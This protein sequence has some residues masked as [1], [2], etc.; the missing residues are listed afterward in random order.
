MRGI[1]LLV[2]LFC[3]S[4]TRIYSQPVVWNSGSMRKISTPAK[5]YT[6]YPRMIELNDRSW[7]CIYEVDGDIRCAKSL[8]QGSTWE[9]VS[10]VAVRE[11]EVNMCVPSVIQLEDGSLLAMYNP[12]PT[13]D[14]TAHHFEIRSKKSYD[15]GLTWRD[16]RLVYQAGN[17]FKNGCWEPAAIQLPSGEIR[18]F[19]ANEGLYIRS[20]EQNISQ[21]TSFDNGLSWSKK[22]VIVSFR[23]GFR[24]GMPIPLLLGRRKIAIAIE[25]NGF[26]QFKPYVIYSEIINDRIYPVLAKDSNRI[27]AL[28]H[29]LADSIYAGAPYLCKL[30]NGTTLLSYQGTEGRK[31]QM[32]Y[33]DMKVMVGDTLAANFEHRSVPFQ[34]P[35]DKSALWNSLMVTSDDTIVAL[36]ATN[37]FNEGKTEIWMIKGRLSEDK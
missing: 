30:K 17:E 23:K 18:L 33:A 20:D 13:K 14:K 27:Y 36:T 6:S 8:D 35:P 29:R 26:E 21:A 3:F 11:P 28:K 1:V 16:E 5:Y 32:K 2:V 22:T 7:M 10:S 19:F 4:L 12:R 9:N 24:D 25:D 31:N 34:I 15:Q 37:A